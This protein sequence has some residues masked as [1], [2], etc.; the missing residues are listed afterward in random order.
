MISSLV[1]LTRAGLADTVP[2]TWLEERMAGGGRGQHG[3]GS[4]ERSTG[5]GEEGDIP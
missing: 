5:G 1:G 3:K 4:H 2:L